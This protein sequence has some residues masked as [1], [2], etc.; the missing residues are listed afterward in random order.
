MLKLKISNPIKIE[1]KIKKN[2]ERYLFSNN[3]NNT[4]I[5]VAGK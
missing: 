5:A 2:Y 3:K 4:L 1:R